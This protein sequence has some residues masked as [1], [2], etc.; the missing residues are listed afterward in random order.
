MRGCGRAGS[1]L[2][3]QAVL[4]EG[5]LVGQGEPQPRRRGVG[6]EEAAG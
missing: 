1:P 5:W 4:A 2:P 6:W 3:G